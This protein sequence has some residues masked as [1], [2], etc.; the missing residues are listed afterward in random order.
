MSWHA[1][2]QGIFP[3][4][5]SNPGP[6]HCRQIIYCLSHQLRGLRTN[7][8]VASSRYLSL[9]LKEVK[10]QIWNHQHIISSKKLIIYITQVCKERLKS[11]SGNPAWKSTCHSQI[12]MFLCFKVKS[13]MSKVL[14]TRLRSIQRW[15]GLFWF[16]FVCLFV[17]DTVMK[18][19]FLQS[20]TYQFHHIFYWKSQYNWMVYFYLGSGDEGWDRQ[21]TQKTT[22]IFHET[23]FDSIVCV[24]IINPYCCK[25]SVAIL[26]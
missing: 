15:V 1:L 10:I 22:L 16:V 4:Q 11:Y 25:F 9:G 13:F 5:G 12:I 21:V 23:I 7:K 20:N 18:F 3:T 24:Y 2:L 17:S 26:V 8:C 19:P 14:H 6:P